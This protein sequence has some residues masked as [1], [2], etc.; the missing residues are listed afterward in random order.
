M[1][2]GQID[3]SNRN[4]PQNLPWWPMETTIKP[5]SRWS[6]P[7][8]SPQYESSLFPLQNLAWYRLDCLTMGGS[9]GEVSESPV[10]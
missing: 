9:P 3:R 5:K 8:L 4:P 10:T 7:T 1:N 2:N 6:S